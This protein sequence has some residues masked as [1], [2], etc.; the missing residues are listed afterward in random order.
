MFTL[1]LLSAVIYIICRISNAS[2]IRNIHVNNKAR[3]SMYSKISSSITIENSYIIKDGYRLLCDNKFV[4][5]N[6][7]RRNHF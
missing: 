6:L 1:I 4:N 5:N 7:T 3:P 2:N